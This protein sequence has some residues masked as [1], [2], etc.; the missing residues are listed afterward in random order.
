[1]GW[2]L[3]FFNGVALGIEHI[4]GDV[5]DGIDWV[6]LIEVLCIRLMLFKLNSNFKH[7]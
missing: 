2:G 5:E 4:D 6:I 3:T 1:M 7:D